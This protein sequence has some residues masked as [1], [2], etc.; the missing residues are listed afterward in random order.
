MS[1]KRSWMQLLAVY[2]YSQV[3]EIVLT[4]MQA[5]ESIISDV[6][7][8]AFSDSSP[9]YQNAQ[10]LCEI[11]LIK[12]PSAVLTSVY[13]HISSFEAS[14]EITRG[15]QTYFTLFAHLFRTVLARV[16]TLINFSFDLNEEKYEKAYVQAV[17]FLKEEVTA[18]KLYSPAYMPLLQ[19]AC[20]YLRE[21]GRSASEM[22]KLLQD[23]ANLIVERTT[24][25]QF[26]ANRCTYTVS[27][28]AVH[29]IVWYL[30]STETINPTSSN[31]EIRVKKYRKAANWLLIKT[32]GKVSSLSSSANLL[33]NA[34]S[35][36][37]SYSE[38][39]NI[40]DNGI[41]TDN[42][43][44]QKHIRYTKQSP[45]ESANCSE[46]STFKGLAIKDDTYTEEI[47]RSY[48]NIDELFIYATPEL[49]LPTFRVENGYGGHLDIPIIPGL[50][51]EDVSEDTFI[52]LSA[53]A[54]YTLLGQ[55]LI[56]DTLSII[57]S[58]ALAKRHITSALSFD[59]VSFFIWCCKQDMKG[60][61][62]T[63]PKNA[64]ITAQS[65]AMDLPVDWNFLSSITV[66]APLFYSFMLLL[67]SLMFLSTANHPLIPSS[68]LSSYSSY[69][70]R[71]LLSSYAQNNTFSTPIINF[72]SAY[73]EILKELP[74][75]MRL[76]FSSIGTGTDDVVHL[77]NRSIMDILFMIPYG[78][79]L[80][81]LK[82]GFRSMRKLI[83]EQTIVLTDTHKDQE[84]SCTSFIPGLLY[85]FDSFVVEPL[86]EPNHGDARIFIANSC[87][88]S[89]LRTGYLL[90][91]YI[92]RLLFPLPNPAAEAPTGFLKYR[93]IDTLVFLQDIDM[94]SFYINECTGAELFFLTNKMHAHINITF[95]LAYRT[96]REG[97][98]FC[99]E[100]LKS[101]NKSL[102]GDGAGPSN[103]RLPYEILLSIYELVYTLPWMGTVKEAASIGTFFSTSY[104]PF[105][106]TKALVTALG[107]HLSSLAV[108]N[109]TTH[110]HRISG[111]IVY[112][113][114]LS[115]SHYKKVASDFM[116]CLITDGAD[117]A[118]LV[119]ALVDSC[120]PREVKSRL[121]FSETA[122]SV[123]YNGGG[124]VAA[125]SSQRAAAP[126]HQ[127]GASPSVK[128]SVGCSLEQSPPFKNDEEAISH[129]LQSCTGSD[130]AE[131][132]GYFHGYLCVLQVVRELMLFLVTEKKLETRERIC[133]VIT[134]IVVKCNLLLSPLPM[135]NS[136]LLE[137]GSID[138]GMY[139]W[140]MTMLY[141]F[142][143]HSIIVLNVR[144]KEL[145]LEQEQILL[146]IQTI[147][148]ALMDLSIKFPQFDSAFSGSE[149]LDSSALLS[150]V[151]ALQK[152]VNMQIRNLRTQNL[153][154]PTN[155]LASII[156]T[157][158]SLLG[159]KVDSLKITLQDIDY[160]IA[161]LNTCPTHHA[162]TAGPMQIYNDLQCDQV[163]EYLTSIESKKESLVAKRTEYSNT[164]T[165][166][167]KEIDAS[168]E[169]EAV[170]NLLRIRDL[171]SNLS[172]SVSSLNAFVRKVQRLEEDVHRIQN[173]FFGDS[174]LF[175]G[176]FTSNLFWIKDHMRA[177]YDQ[178]L[179]NQNSISSSTDIA[180][181]PSLDFLM[182]N[183]NCKFTMEE[184]R[185]SEFSERQYIHAS[186]HLQMGCLSLKC[187]LE[188]TSEDFLPIY[189]E[190]VR[191]RFSKCADLSFCWQ[192]P[193]S[194][195]P[196]H[197]FFSF[198]NQESHI[199]TL[200]IRSTVPSAN[201]EA[202][203]IE[204][205]NLFTISNS[206]QIGI[207]FMSNA[208]ISIS[209]LWFLAQFTLD[210]IEKIANSEDAIPAIAFLYG[211]L[212]R[213]SEIYSQPIKLFLSCVQK[214]FYDSATQDCAKLG[215]T[216]KYYSTYNEYYAFRQAYT[217]ANPGYAGSLLSSNTPHFYSIPSMLERM[218]SKIFDAKDIPVQAHI[219]G[220]RE[221]NGS[222]IGTIGNTQYSMSYG[223]MCHYYTQT[224]LLPMLYSLVPRYLFIHG[225]FKQYI[226]NKNNKFISKLPLLLMKPSDQ[227]AQAA[228]LQIT[229][230]DGLPVMGPRSYSKLAS[231][232]RSFGLLCGRIFA[233]HMPIKRCFDIEM[234]VL[235]GI[236]AACG[237]LLPDIIVFGVY[238]ALSIYETNPFTQIGALTSYAILFHFLD[239]L[240]SNGLVNDM[241][242]N[243]T[244]MKLQLTVTT[245]KLTP[246]FSKYSPQTWE[247]CT[248]PKILSY[249]LFD[250]L[251]RGEGS[252]SEI[253]HKFLSQ[254]TEQLVSEL[255][256][257]YKSVLGRLSSS[258]DL[259]KE[260]QS[261][262]VMELLLDHP[263]SILRGR[264]DKVM[265]IL[266]IGSNIFQRNVDTQCMFKA[267]VKRWT[268]ELTERSHTSSNFDIEQLSTFIYHVVRELPLATSLLSDELVHLRKLTTNKSSGSHPHV[269]KS[270]HSKNKSSVSHH[271]S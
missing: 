19:Q 83:I 85:I 125:K 25:A 66:R 237:L 81:L 264:I 13:S 142:L 57:M 60:N 9:S 86:C 76:S 231:R 183:A 203:L 178:G 227:D 30:F 240:I 200:A 123:A 111:H 154:E 193:P 6:I 150:L 134:L 151:D 242:N 209:P 248:I 140:F 109:V 36:V 115:T 249:F 110:L 146:S 114:I 218:I 229:D 251:P 263:I 51:A 246:F 15:Y 258:V 152:V 2:H 139:S 256:H 65:P 228:G 122:F 108:P 72:F 79:L 220:Q 45:I 163:N 166:L 271:S 234:L 82:Q 148:S 61:L 116:Y 37:S 22:F 196:K 91:V 23:T 188:D 59:L 107:T 185:E 44:L 53:S 202:M 265:H 205:A 230:T 106:E 158:T 97:P 222:T 68:L 147:R 262:R 219:Q 26:S 118:F 243:V 168:G 164:L 92:L 71:K 137:G 127:T 31:G 75:F 199:F 191:M 105:L 266:L 198:L 24:W 133:S 214:F 254:G 190:T 138:S 89:L 63:C 52:S 67:L 167:L 233:H 136:M 42:L 41:E 104:S 187:S 131:P 10:D 197:S 247:S 143:H 206:T 223:D 270:R 12:S 54:L 157:R 17:V 195:T 64:F 213:T 99:N 96:F 238:L 224:T 221:N 162:T 250:R 141:A 189:E 215:E 119:A 74:S 192:D 172:K 182:L 33:A 171:V 103:M 8:E 260:L 40:Y 239:T 241:L 149:A 70:E 210:T 93:T 144:K 159:D 112:G 18:K 132:F 225:V 94:L 180:V 98:E 170:D 50:W 7:A 226:G 58:F 43:L 28:E 153:S 253:V 80:L 35:S 32:F 161:E 156:T 261:Q 1:H 120:F 169:R 21:D 11:L 102:D 128:D 16:C 216:T 126:G 46:L 129:Q 113:S 135:M 257:E 174:G 252:I 235:M 3:A 124:V 101:L 176:R 184:F 121:L 69:I 34:Y 145:L 165:Q 155:P 5:D 269:H 47:A 207:E 95:I 73:S 87:L 4:A 255:Q 244:H 38:R 90:D 27:K 29:Y 130:R 56:L 77:L 20:S 55:P 49:V 88:Q 194:C 267:A 268:Y 245:L 84:L 259:T 117:P 236:T 204:Y 14:K 232:C 217:F 201:F 179:G 100:F 160:K 186:Y 39:L 181:T 177:I 208:Y 211:A 175:S 48:D 78:F 62:V 173:W 212:T